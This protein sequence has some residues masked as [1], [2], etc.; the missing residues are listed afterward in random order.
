MAQMRV[1]F[2]MLQ[3][4]IVNMIAKR[5][6]QTQTTGAEKRTIMLGINA[7]GRK[8]P[9]YV[10]FK[11]NTVP[12]EKL[13]TLTYRMRQWSGICLWGSL[14]GNLWVWPGVPALVL[15]ALK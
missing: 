14:V 4:M 2:D 6:L 11:I 1:W 13:M 5:S 3:N 7:D 9:P 12:S 15:Q 8:H 10:T